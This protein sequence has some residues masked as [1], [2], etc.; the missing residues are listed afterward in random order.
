MQIRR[1]SEY[2]GRKSISSKLAMRRSTTY[3]PPMSNANQSSVPA[4][5][6]KSIAMKDQRTFSEKPEKQRLFSVLGDQNKTNQEAPSSF[7]P[8]SATT[9]SK[10]N[11]DL[12]SDI[13]DDSQDVLKKKLPSKPKIAVDT[14]LENDK[15]KHVKVGTLIQNTT[16]LEI[17]DFE[18]SLKKVNSEAKLPASPTKPEIATQ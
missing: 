8:S 2:Q 3:V 11:E 13:I 1:S 12:V 5:L 18:S 17:N 4:E 6:P 10:V 7:E 15:D 14:V 16:K 9:E